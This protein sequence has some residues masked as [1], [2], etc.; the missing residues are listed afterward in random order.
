MADANHTSH[1]FSKS[2]DSK[3]ITR[4]TTILFQERRKTIK[5]SKCFDLHSKMF[6]V[7]S[8]LKHTAIFQ[9]EKLIILASKVSLCEFSQINFLYLLHLLRGFSACIPSILGLI[10]AMKMTLSAI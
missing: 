6:N 5:E 2:S 7:L 3:I 1:T 8:T 9:F 10:V 4:N